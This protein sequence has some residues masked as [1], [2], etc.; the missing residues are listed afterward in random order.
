M[1]LRQTAELAA[2]LAARAD[3]IDSVSRLRI[4]RSVNN[5]RNCCRRRAE[6]WRE[7]IDHSDTSDVEKIRPHVI[8][9]FGTEKLT[10]VW[11]AV[12]HAFGH[13]TDDAEIAQAAHNAF[14]SHQTARHHA[15]TWMLNRSDTDSRAIAAIDV[16]R[17]QCERWTDVLLGITSTPVDWHLYAHQ[18]ERARDFAD[19]NP[20]TEA[21]IRNP[22]LFRSLRT[23]FAAPI[24]H[25]STPILLHEEI[26]ASLTSVLPSAS[27]LLANSAPI[28]FR[29]RATKS[30]L[31][32]SRLMANREAS[33]PHQ[34]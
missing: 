18:P 24:Y 10:S 8:E 4:V 27:R 26:A 1:N 21:G 22:M 2:H 14:L 7:L 19:E 30:S 5:Y 20:G 17:R 6:S 16:V 3:T 13:R 9:I 31:R 33:D 34:E 32:F 29:S 12:F 28:Q 15:M 25:F 23:A 11:S